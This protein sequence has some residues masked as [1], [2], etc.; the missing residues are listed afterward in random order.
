MI[1]DFNARQVYVEYLIDDEGQ[2]TVLVVE[3]H[4]QF[5]QAEPDFEPDKLRALIENLNE[6]R[7][8]LDYI[9]AIRLVRVI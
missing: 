5:D 1:T 6:H 2:R 7:K 3:T 8:S 9:D 4:L